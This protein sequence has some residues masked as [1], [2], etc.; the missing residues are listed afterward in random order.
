MH[1]LPAHLLIDFESW[2]GGGW[3]IQKLLTIKQKKKKINKRLKKEIRGF[4]G[5]VHF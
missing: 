3:L 2:G 5:R 4:D 1:V